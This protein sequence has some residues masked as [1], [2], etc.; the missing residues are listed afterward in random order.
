MCRRFSCE[1]SPLL[2]I[3]VGWFL[4]AHHRIC[5]ECTGRRCLE[6]H[7]RGRLAFEF[8]VVS[9]EVIG[10]V[11]LMSRQCISESIQ[12]WWEKITMRR[13][14]AFKARFVNIRIIC[15]L[16]LRLP[17]QWFG[18]LWWEIGMR[19]GLPLEPK[20]VVK[21]LLGSSCVSV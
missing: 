1:D 19:R 9:C 4:Q 2:P 3:S 17:L 20:L 8:R 12:R 11:R 18:N 5:S 15:H 10:C 14:F 13:R 6:I 7:V 16:T 21:C